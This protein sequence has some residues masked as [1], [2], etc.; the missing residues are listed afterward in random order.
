M[1]P[2]I[3]TTRWD[4]TARAVSAALLAVSFL[5]QPL[6]PAFA[7]EE[8]AVPPDDTSLQSNTESSEQP[9]TADFETADSF[10]NEAPL[11]E[12]TGEVQAEDTGEN[13]EEPPVVSPTTNHSSGVDRQSL[14]HVDEATGALVYEYALHL[15]PGRNQLHP[16]VA[17]RHDSQRQEN[18][19]L[20][21]GWTLTLPAV[22][23]VNKKGTDALYS[24]N[25]FNS[26]FD[27]ELVTV[28]AG[29][30]RPK[31]ENGA[32]LN[33]EFDGDS[34]IAIDK[35]GT[36][37][38][39]G[40][41]IQARQD[42]PADATRTYRWMLEEVRDTN[43][44]VVRYEYSK[45]AGQIYPVRIVYTGHDA[46]DGIF[47]VVF[48]REVRPDATTSYASG[49]AVETNYRVRE[50]AVN[51]NGAPVRAYTLTYT[52]A[53]N[54]LRSLLA[55]VV[56]SGWDDAGNITSLP[57]VR[58]DYESATPG[59]VYDS[60]WNPPVPAVVNGVDH[61]MRW[62]DI[63]GDGLL[64]I[65]CHNGKNN[66]T[67]GRYNQVIKHNTGEGWITAAGWS[68]PSQQDN[69]SELE[70]FLNS[71]LEDTGLRLIDV[72]G[73]GLAD[74]V[75]GY[76]FQESYVYLNTGSG[77]A[78][79][80]SWELPIPFHDGGR[81]Y[82]M[83]MG[84]INGDGLL[85]I[86]CANGVVNASCGRNNAAILINTGAGWENR[87]EWTMPR[88]AGNPSNAQEVFINASYEDTGL[89][90]LDVN[91]DK[92]A[93]LV[94]GIDSYSYVYLNTGSGWIYDSAW[95]IPLPFTRNAR[96][97]GM[98]MDDANGDGLIDIL[99]HNGAVSGNCGRYNPTIRFNTG[100]S[101]EYAPSWEF[102][103]QQNDPSRREVFVDA[104]YQDTGLRLV[105]IN[106]DGL[107]DLVRGY[108]SI[109]YA[110]INTG[111]RADYLRA[112][113]YVEGGSTTIAYRPTSSFREGSG[114]LSNP[115]LPF[116]FDAVSEII[117]DDGFGNIEQYQY[118]YREGEYYFG[119][120]PERKFAGFGVVTKTDAEGNITKTYYHQG[121]DTN[122]ALGEHADHI[123]KTGRPYR[124]EVY[125]G[126]GDLYQVNISKW[127]HHPLGGE[128]H[129]VK[130]TETLELTY[131]GNATHR[132]RAVSY[133]YDDTNGNLI[134]TI[135][136][137][138][139]AG[140]PDG[141][142]TDV[143]LDKRTTTIDY[144]ENTAEHIFGLLSHELT[145]NQTGEK[146]R[147]AKFYYDEQAFGEVTR[148]NLT[149]EEHWVEGGQYAD[150]EYVYNTYGLVTEMEDPRGKT[151][152]YEHDQHNLYPE[153]VTNP[154]SHETEY[155][156]DYSSGQV[157]TTTDPNG[158][159]FETVYDGLDRR[160]TEK[161]PDSE[162]PSTLVTKTTY[163]YDDTT[164][165]RKVKETAYLDGSINVETYRYVDGLGRVV[166]ER[167]E[168]ET[169]NEWS[170]ADYVYN[171]RG[172]L[173]KES[174]PYFGSGAAYTSPTTNTELYTTHSYDPLQRVFLSEDALGT[175][176]YTYDDWETTITDPLGNSKEFAR[177][178]YDNLVEVI[179]HNDS[180]TYTTTYAYD[181]N[182]NLTKITDALENIR[183][184]AYDGLSRRL[185]AEDLH[186]SGDGT[187][188][189]WTYEYDDA[190]NL[191]SQTDPKSQIVTFA[192]DDLNRVLFEDY[193]GAAGTEVV[194][195]YDTCVEGVGRLCGV[196]T[197]SVETDY[198]YTALGAVAAET[199]SVNDISY[200][201]AYQYDRQGNLTDVVYPDDTEVLYQYN[202]AG[203]LETV[204][205]ADGSAIIT[206]LEYAPTGQVAHKEFA[207]GITSTYTYD[208]EERYRLQNIRSL[209]GAETLQDLTYTYDVVGNIT[210]V[211]D[212][213]DTA[214]AKTVTYTYD[215][216]YRLTGATVTGAANG[217]NYT[218][219]YAY[220]ALGNIT[221]A[222]QNG[223][224]SYEGHL[225]GGFA[226]PHAVT[227]VGGMSYT[228]DENGNLLSTAP[229]AGGWTHTWDYRNRLVSSSDG[230]QTLTY[231]YDHA[232]NRVRKT[233]SNGGETV[234]V[235]QY[236]DIEDSIPKAYIYTGSE[237]VATLTLLP[238]NTE[239]LQAPSPTESEEGTGNLVVPQPS[240]ADLGVS[241]VI[242]N[243]APV[244]HV[245]D[246]ATYTV[247][248][249]NS[250][251]GKA[252]DITLTDD[253]D[254]TKM[255]IAGGTLKTQGGLS[256]SDNG[257]QLSCTMPSLEVNP[258]VQPSV[259]YTATLL[260]SGTVTN[261][262]TVSANTNDP[263]PNNNTDSISLA[264]EVP[265][266]PALVFHHQDHL[267]G[268]SV[269]TDESGNT[270]ELLD[271]YPYGAI[272]INE[273]STA[274]DN[275]YKFTGKELDET[276]LYYYGA[277]YYGSDMARFI[278]QDPLF[279]TLHT[280]YLADPQQW[281]SYA[282]SRNNPVRFI[283]ETGEKVAEYQP[284][285]P[286]N[287][288]YYQNGDLLGK[289]RGIEIR[290]RGPD[291]KTVNSGYQCVD[292]VKAFAKQEHNGAILT[293]RG[294]DYG[295]QEHINNVFETHNPNNPGS[296][297]VHPNES[298][299]MPQEDDIISWGDTTG[300]NPAGHVGIVAEVVFDDKSK[301]GW[302]Y[303]V[304]Q[305]WGFEQ[306]IF[307]QPLKQNKDGTFTVGGRGDYTVQGWTRYKENQNK[308]P[309]YTNIRHTPA[310]R[311]PLR[312]SNS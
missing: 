295:N 187:F 182:N 159:M 132:D 144:A 44:N 284:Y 11:E 157:R 238:E 66:A 30:Y 186:D 300:N 86:V 125:D 19:V 7:Q 247:Y 14:P 171:S 312:Q 29:A 85:D 34:W 199:K 33:Y 294:V 268:T 111:V 232:G 202:N 185:S 200:T 263:D 224:Y 48:E 162:T 216:L 69:P 201:T 250:G 282:Y 270:I 122:T 207:N 130:G 259:T 178:A 113:T 39:F 88:R 148:G 277:R 52:S 310:P 249:G 183:N 189:T 100:L 196:Q 174:L 124:I 191:T 223:I 4:T 9:A 222:S 296:Y 188:G 96:D 170:V 209:G 140:S 115:N 77:W 240:E 293:G 74:L 93:D 235:N 16:A 154:L 217:E 205:L 137:G 257:T 254:E 285:L 172:L 181:G 168:A 218:R 175:T 275:A 146:V 164:M 78:Y 234:Y 103:P 278:S 309:T 13:L 45:N 6:S 165:P 67:C 192:Y 10:Q 42:D 2:F 242:Y 288:L 212:I 279:W 56:E 35:A 231:T 47:E 169:S 264:V 208:D 158:R 76:D 75:R 3:H 114:E 128:A 251:P 287:G 28:S 80:P 150:T 71:N 156:Y 290:S 260:A 265:L 120:Y 92:L 79:E 206:D 64:D 149:K 253:Y 55:S 239:P 195:S 272:R 176:S 62:G 258:L 38:L 151:T 133:T 41:N 184:F 25:Y 213:S 97:Y 83:R 233:S 244:Y 286:S 49:F 225:G 40:Q 82:G 68:L 145:T 219:T 135:E 84:D 138:E 197:V 63:N 292:C 252:T 301:S 58:F 94:T 302:V 51:I 72:N 291:V 50:V 98:R 289:Y 134:E 73:D 18:G 194:Y 53:D 204:S 15:P 280:D 261:T 91:G 59:W 81:D 190:G 116:V 276:D 155:T 12:S 299:V 126:A 104:L 139:V 220:D 274:Y 210:D 161:V 303:S 54:G 227:S 20:G 262:A 237:K 108:G 297:T 229:P 22:E 236:F 105:D 203:F 255:Q 307:A 228:Y 241:K 193:T 23:R 61:G 110:Y 102:P 306:G 131:D 118:D 221:E 160:I 141:T 106:G 24:E 147:E 143:G 298:T 37:Y 65:V 5:L 163:D 304:E 119:V 311:R 36:R 123:A 211:V 121:N 90:L 101:W 21:W 230:A 70:A 226:N 27:G 1:E 117:H 8:E 198:T 112:I 245:G 127:E 269:D 57:A 179:E 152:L 273:Q 142:F 87:Q 99:C 266:V 180:A 95:D 248:V 107:A 26:S 89:R 214:T 271:Y 243:Q 256:C 17:I 166:Q 136:W 31:V 215:D 308:L 46:A 109:R 129:F 43:D 305:N 281:N 167:R 153:I 60:T 32:F 283:D 173:E 246:T 267:G 177:D